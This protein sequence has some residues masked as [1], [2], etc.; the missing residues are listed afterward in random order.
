MAAALDIFW[1][2]RYLLPDA[3]FR[4]TGNDYNNIDWNPTNIDAKPS[5]FQ[6]QTLNPDLVTQFKNSVQKQERMAALVFQ[7]KNDLSLK[8]KFL[9]YKDRHPDATFADYLI[10]LEKTDIG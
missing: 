7:Y 10:Y 9:E 8:A 3:K 4:V 2:I 1:T 6:L 5:L